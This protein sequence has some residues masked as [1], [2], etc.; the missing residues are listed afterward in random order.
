MDIIREDLKSLLEEKYLRFNTTSFI[1]SD[2]VAIPHLFTKKEDIEIAG[3]L[4]AT[5][6]WGSR[7]V[8]L[9]NARHLMEMTDM[10]PHGFLLHASRHE[11][12]PFRKFIHR[13]FR[14]DDCIFFLTSLKN[15]YRNHG[16]LEAAFGDIRTT[17]VKTAIAR[18]R[19]A[20]LTP[21][22]SVRVEKHLADP[23][24]G[25]S[26]KRINMF[27][28]WMIRKDLCGVDFGIWNNASPADLMCPLDVH[29]GRIA[30]M[31]G[32]LTRKSN[33][34]QAVEELTANLRSLDPLDPVKY[35]Y[36]LF[37]MG[38]IDKL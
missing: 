34:W 9:R 6:S 37:G 29:S 11:M 7:P 13:T 26:A 17:G 18:F 10:A 25:S 23:F 31:L 14:G 27:L 24:R 38:A 21:R 32:L 1:E 16:G 3:F 19:N 35:D 15:I 22:H 4:T 2:P 20:F 8:I 12:E 33:D 28:R 5:I 36:A 30:R